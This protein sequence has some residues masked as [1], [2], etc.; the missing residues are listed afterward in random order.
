M[1]PA[2]GLSKLAHNRPKFFRPSAL[3]CDGCHAGSPVRAWLSPGR[4]PRL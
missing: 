1:E 4:R 2:L 3:P